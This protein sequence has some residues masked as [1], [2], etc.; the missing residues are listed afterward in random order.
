MDI[1]MENLLGYKKF[2]KLMADFAPT[3]LEPV[4][5]KKLKNY[6]FY[7]E[8]TEIE[9]LIFKGFSE[10][11]TS[12]DS[13][14]LIENFISINPP[15][16]DNINYSNYLIYHVH[17]YLQE[18]YIMKDRLDRYIEFINENYKQKIGENEINEIKENLKKIIKSAFDNITKYQTGARSRHVHD[19]R[20]MDEELKWLSS[21]TLLANFHDEFKIES[22]QAYSIAKDKWFDSI[23][24]NNQ[25]LEK[26]LDM[27]F[28]AIY[29]I[30]TLDNKVILPNQ[31][32]QN[33]TTR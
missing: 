32:I 28:N 30:I 29:I 20:Y 22:E 16:N 9:F 15:K 2:E 17:N 7:I 21:T 19:E 23:N 33:E 8:Q 31:I 12:F 1:R 24:N 27:Y 13:L 11:S 18:M 6:D 14:K 3:F 5:Q 10:I 25:E 4:V 26:I